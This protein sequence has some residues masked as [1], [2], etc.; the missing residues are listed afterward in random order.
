MASP[1]MQQMH[2]MPQNLMYPVGTPTIPSPQLGQQ[3]TPLWVSELFSRLENMSAKLSTLDTVNETV[4]KIK[5]QLNSVEQ[6]TKRLDGKIK[7]IEKSTESISQFFDEQKQSVD[8]I[9]CVIKDM[10][11]QINNQAADI[12]KT[13]VEV[14]SENDR[15]KHELLDIKMRSMR[16]NLLFFNITETNGEDCVNVIDEFCGN[17]LGIRDAKDI[18][19]DR[20]HRIGKYRDNKPRPI[21]AK[22]NFYGDR[23]RIRK[24][25]KE[26]LDGKTYKI[27]QQLPQEIRE[28]RRNLQ[29]VFDDLV[30]KGGKPYFKMDHYDLLLL[31]ETWLKKEEVVHLDG[32][33][34]VSF[35][36]RSVNIGRRNE[37]GLGVFCKAGKVNGIS[38]E[39]KIQN[40]IIIS[41]LSK[42]YFSMNDDVYICLVYIPHAKSEYYNVVDFDFFE[43]LTDITCEFEQ[44]GKVFIAGDMNARIGQE[45]DYIVINNLDRFVY[46]KQYIDGHYDKRRQNDWFGDKCR[47]QKMQFNSARNKYYRNPT[48]NNKSKYLHERCQY[49]K[50]K[51]SAKFRYM[52]SKCKQLSKLSKTNPKKF[53]QTVKP[54]SK[55]KCPVPVNDFYKMFQELLGDR[56]SDFDENNYIDQS[57]ND[58]FVEELDSPFTETEILSTIKKNFICNNIV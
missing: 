14:K 18:K 54:Q 58:V 57:I 22:F 16:D 48:E 51:R 55:Q 46:G 25:G 8:S 43:T 13:F 56:H 11:K 17:K 6:E 36:N 45:T 33:V 35:I 37:G 47:R 28:R 42:S 49:N 24:L 27:T 26:K 52:N 5:S 19:I 31:T 7:D 23:E 34:D 20:A 38:V 32:F 29:P 40:G 44:K 3:T 53:W 30:K 10:T 4:N 41:K 15:L 12:D 21:V 39:K 50:I 1:N 2:S 9:K